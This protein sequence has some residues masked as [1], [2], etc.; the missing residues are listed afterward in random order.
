MKKISPQQM[1]SLGMEIHQ[2]ESEGTKDSRFRLYISQ[3]FRLNKD[4][5]FIKKGPFKDLI[6]IIKDY[7]PQPDC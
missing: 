4:Q 3:D 6:L 1:V 7:G 2:P 5:Y